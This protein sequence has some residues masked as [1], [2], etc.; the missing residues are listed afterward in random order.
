M[1]ITFFNNLFFLFPDFK[2]L[3]DFTGILKFFRKNAY[4]T[5][6]LLTKDYLIMICKTKVTIYLLV[7]SLNY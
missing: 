5:V 2:N 3:P 7:I 1:N 6:F 4:K